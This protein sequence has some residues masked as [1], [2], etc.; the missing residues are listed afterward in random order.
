[1][2]K[3]VEPVKSAT[4]RGKFRFSIKLLLLF[5]AL[6]CILLSFFSRTVATARIE[7]DIS[8]RVAPPGPQNRTHMAI[9]KS[10]SVLH[11]TVSDPEI[12]QCSVVN[13]HQDPVLWLDEKLQVRCQPSEVDQKLIVSV[14]L[15]GSPYERNQLVRVVDKVVDICLNQIE[16]A[17]P[18]HC[19]GCS[20]KL[21][22]YAGETR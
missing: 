4:R 21:I 15:S 14:S 5:V 10:W 19:Q 8:Q 7:I 13:R 22:Q 16:T 18:Y 11:G 6:C 2:N 3:S 20:Y 12:S 17:S 1:M 9:W